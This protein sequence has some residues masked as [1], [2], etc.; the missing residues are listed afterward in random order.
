M[1]SAPR[2]TRNMTP[3]KSITLGGA[4][5]ITEL[6]SERVVDKARVLAHLQEQLAELK[7]QESAEHGNT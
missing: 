2:T 7:N 4:L 5:L 3:P 6:P 1:S